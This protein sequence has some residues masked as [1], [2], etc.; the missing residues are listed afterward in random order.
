MYIVLHQPTGQHGVY[1]VCWVKNLQ[2]QLQTALYGLC[3]QAG[4]LQLVHRL[5]NTTVGV[6]SL[7]STINFH[8]STHLPKSRADVRNVQQIPIHVIEHD[9]Q[10][11]SISLEMGLG[12]WLIYTPR[13][14]IVNY[15]LNNQKSNI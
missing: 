6:V 5:L 4:L 2:R 3:V 10:P 7:A 9:P 1:F 13:G 12:S 8:N 14:G 11:P 15:V